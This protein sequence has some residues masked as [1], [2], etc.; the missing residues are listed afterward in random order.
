MEA[1]GIIEAHQ[2]R[3]VVITSCND[4]PLRRRFDLEA[5]MGH[6][7]DIHPLGAGE[8]GISDIN[9]IRLRDEILR[10]CGI[11][12]I[13]QLAQM[14]AELVG[15]QLG[16]RSGVNLH[17]HHNLSGGNLER[18]RGVGIRA[19]FVRFGPCRD[20][21]E[22]RTRDADD[23]TAAMGMLNWHGLTWMNE[24][25][26]VKMAFRLE[27]TTDCTDFTDFWGILCFTF[28]CGKPIP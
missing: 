26:E 16:H 27:F 14:R 19:A 8:L 17:L 4:H 9:H 12:R 5:V 7:A 15:C 10:L 2:G 21:G 3:P 24:N 23:E 18:L 6:R 11:L 22:H 13:G 1:P 28:R 20:D 25:Y